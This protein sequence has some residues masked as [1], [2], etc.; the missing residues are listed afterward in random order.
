MKIR[1]AQASTDPRR[2]LDERSSADPG[3]RS[4]AHMGRTGGNRL[5]SGFGGGDSA[6]RLAC[7][8]KSAASNSIPPQT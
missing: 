8:L 2:S 3:S 4:S 7:E 5:I 6:S 1:R